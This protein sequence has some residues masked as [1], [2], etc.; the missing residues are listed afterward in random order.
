MTTIR[1]EFINGTGDKDIASSLTWNR[2]KPG[3]PWF[4]HGGAY[5]GLN[6]LQYKGSEVGAIEFIKACYKQAE[7]NGYKL[8]VDYI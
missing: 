2:T 4:F 8:V 7:A 3:D 1:V 6:C 5:D